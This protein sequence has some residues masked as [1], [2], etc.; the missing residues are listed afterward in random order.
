MRRSVGPSPTTWYAMCTP[1]GVFAYRTSGTSICPPPVP[2]PAVRTPSG[3]VPAGVL[4]LRLRNPSLDGV[5]PQLSA[6]HPAVT[7]GSPPHGEP[8][9]GSVFGERVALVATLRPWATL[10]RRTSSSLRVHRG[11]GRPPSSADSVASSVAW[12]NLPGRYWRSSVRPEEPA[13]GTR[14]RPCSWTYS[15]SARSRSTKRPGRQEARSSSTAGSLIASSLRR[16]SR[17]RSSA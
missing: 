10:P 15:C 9:S 13:P 4:P 17:G 7:L 2:V 8:K 11:Q 14:T 16:P 12:T 3:L 1:W 5:Q 6:V